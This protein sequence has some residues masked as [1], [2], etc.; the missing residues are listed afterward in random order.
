MTLQYVLNNKNMIE[1]GWQI[2]GKGYH[3]LIHKQGHSNS[4][5]ILPRKWHVFKSKMKE[6]KV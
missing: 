6:S 1:V 4:N 2:Y 5:D 3:N